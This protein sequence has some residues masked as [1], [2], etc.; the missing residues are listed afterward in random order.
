MKGFRAVKTDEEE[1]HARPKSMR[2]LREADLMEHE[3]EAAENGKSCGHCF[4]RKQSP[5]SGW[6]FLTL[7]PKFTPGGKPPQE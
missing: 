7:N 3:H 2:I 5:F 6:Q 1:Y 4:L